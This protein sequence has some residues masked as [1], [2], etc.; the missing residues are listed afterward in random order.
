[1]SSQYPSIFALGT[2]QVN[3]LSHA[4]SSLEL[5]LQIELAPVGLVPVRGT[6]VS[7]YYSKTMGRRQDWS[8]EDQ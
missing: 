4:Q 5:P 6:P 8:L 1:M 7:Q 2:S 3:H